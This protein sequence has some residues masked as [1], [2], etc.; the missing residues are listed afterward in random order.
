MGYK[1]RLPGACQIKKVVK[2]R[3]GSVE[4]PEGGSLVEATSLSSTPSPKLSSKL[5]FSNNYPFYEVST[6]CIS[7]HSP[8]FSSPC[9]CRSAEPT[10]VS[11][12]CRILTLNERTHGTERRHPSWHIGRDPLPGLS[13]DRQKMYFCELGNVSRKELRQAQNRLAKRRS[14]RY[15]QVASPLDAQTA[16]ASTSIPF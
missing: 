3:Y 15:S 6:S 8:Q 5:S 7:G 12:K 14:R 13:R 9:I 1:I 4:T 16:S 2:L 11:D 10:A